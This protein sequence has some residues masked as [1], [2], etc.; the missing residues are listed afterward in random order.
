MPAPTGNEFL[1]E[2]LLGQSVG[3]GFPELVSPMETPGAR[4]ADLFA[5]SPTVHYITDKLQPFSR[6]YI[7]WIFLI[8]KGNPSLMNVSTSNSRA[9]RSRWKSPPFQHWGQPSCSLPGLWELQDSKG[10]GHPPLPRAL[11]Q[12]R[13]LGRHGLD[14]DPNRNSCTLD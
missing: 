11:Q 13:V 6:H 10:R 12:H 8:H 1:A 4:G 2:I 5:C 3:H 14:T 9:G 7:L